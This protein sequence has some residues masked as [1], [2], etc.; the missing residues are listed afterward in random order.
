M[1]TV[2]CVMRLIP[3]D[4]NSEKQFD[5]REPRRSIE[6]KAIDNRLPQT[7]AKQESNDYAEGS[8]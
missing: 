3:V 1:M 8:S 4:N 5:N 6:C 7:T 2:D